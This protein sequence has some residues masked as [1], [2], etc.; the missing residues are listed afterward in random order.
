MLC[1]PISFCVLGVAAFCFMSDIWNSIGKRHDLEW[2]GSLFC[3]GMCKRA[4]V[5]P[6]AATSTAAAVIRKVSARVMMVF[7]IQQESL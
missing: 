6:A 3:F 5:A 4:D 2:I 1:F 7:V